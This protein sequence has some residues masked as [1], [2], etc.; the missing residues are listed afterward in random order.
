LR[1]CRAARRPGAAPAALLGPPCPRP[2]PDRP[3][4]TSWW[5]QP[6]HVPARP[7]S[8]GGPSP[9]PLVR[10]CSRTALPLPSTTGL[11]LLRHAWTPSSASG[12]VSSD[13][14]PHP[15]VAPH[16]L[17]FSAPSLALSVALVTPLRPASL[18]GF[19]ARVRL[20]ARCFDT[21]FR[22]A[23]AVGCCLVSHAV[24]LVLDCSR[25]CR[26]TSVSLRRTA[27]YTAFGW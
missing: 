14:V 17:P 19:C 11:R 23:S 24:A 4:L 3:A 25:L 5:W 27:V 12:G 6:S 8:G 2:A 21:P 13:L 1:R 22:P 26:L 7:G 20:R 10:C 18:A 9:P 16:G 15:R